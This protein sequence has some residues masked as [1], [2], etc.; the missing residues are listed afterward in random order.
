VSFAPPPAT[1]LRAAALAALALAAGTGRAAAPATCGT[2]WAAAGAGIGGPVRAL[3][4]TDIAGEPALYAG[5]LFSSSG[6]TQLINVARWNGAA[7]APL[8][9]G[10]NGEVF[11]LASFKGE[12][13]VAGAF[14]GPSDG[15]PGASRI[16][17]WDG[18][19]WRALAGGVDSTVRTLALF[20]DGVGGGVGGVGGVGGGGGVAALFVGG[21]FTNAG[22][23]PARRVA[24]WDGAAW[25]PLGAGLNGGALAMAVWDDGSGA[26]LFVGGPFTE[27]G[28]AQARGV[29]RWKGGVWTPLSPAGVGAAGGGAGIVRA[30]VVLPAAHGGG[31][32]AA[33]SFVS[34]GGA[35]ASNIARWNGA[36]WSVFGAGVTGARVDAMRV[37]DEGD[38]PALFV[39]G[40]FSGAGGGPAANAARWNGSAWSPL[41][42]GT[43]GPVSALEV[44]DEAAL[45]RAPALYAGGE[46]TSAGGAPAADVARWGEFGCTTPV[47][48]TQPTDVT[49]APGKRAELFVLAAGSE[50]LGFQWR[51]NGVALVDGVSVIGAR[52]HRIVIDPATI[53]DEGAYDIVVTGPGGSATSDAATLTI[54]PDCPGD[55]SGD[56]RVNFID[57]TATLVDWGAVYL[58]L[59]GTGS[60]DANGDGV[61]NFADITAAL[62][63]WMGAC[64]PPPH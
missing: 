1:T 52:S 61:V 32:C 22:G 20:D 41:A 5:G 19:N 63:N 2:G 17:R 59:P 46:F 16:A 24:R 26:A 11:A 56:G 34:A 60:G 6:A 14:T 45:G 27:A 40:D 48:T 55:S 38:G 53:L 62:A 8:G 36:F 35:P 3:R 10:V 57:I 44:F 13:I 29:A 21:F 49:T 4:T 39:A 37:F 15:T 47:I 30:L 7:W 33:G 58:P 23:V 50:P 25:S 42:A 31:L 12:L 18:A 64:P 43:N 54:R 28:G 9:T 51:R